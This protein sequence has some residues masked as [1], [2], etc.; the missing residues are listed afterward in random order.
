MNALYDG[1]ARSMMLGQFSWMS[2]YL[3][4][5][6]WTGTPDYV[7][8]DNTIADIKGRGG[9]DIGSSMTIEGQAVAPDGTGKTDRVLIPGIPVGEAA[10]WLTLCIRGSTFDDS[11]LVFF[12]D[13]VEGFPFAPNG[14]DLLIQPDWITQRGWFRP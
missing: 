12:A 2:P 3:M 10:T 7:A 6:A 5:V 11:R 8:T 9:T 13:E 1:A 4:V 14:L